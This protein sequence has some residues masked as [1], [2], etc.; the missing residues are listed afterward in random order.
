ML[1][2]GFKANLCVYR[3]EDDAW[4]L[5]GLDLDLGGLTP[6]FDNVESFELTLDRCGNPVVMALASKYT[7]QLLEK[8]DAAGSPYILKVPVL[9]HFVVDITVTG[10][11]LLDSGVYLVQ[12]AGINTSAFALQIDFSDPLH[13]LN[14]MVTGEPS[15]LMAGLQPIS[16]AGG[17]TVT[18]N[19]N[20]S[21][22]APGIHYGELKVTAPHAYHPYLIPVRLAKYGT[23]RTLP[24]PGQY[25]DLGSAAQNA[26]P[27][28]VIT[29]GGGT[30]DGDIEGN[31][32]GVEI[33]GVSP[34]KTVIENVPGITGVS[35]FTISN[36][37]ILPDSDASAPFIIDFMGI[38]GT[39]T[40][41]NVLFI[42]PNRSI[43]IRG[44]GEVRF[45]FC[46]VFSAFGGSYQK[47][48]NE[49]LT[50]NTLL[51]EDATVH[52]DH[53]I[54]CFGFITSFPGT[55]NIAWSAIGNAELSGIVNLDQ[56]I[57]ASFG[58][59]GFVNPSGPDY[60]FHLMSTA[61]HWDDALGIFTPDGTTSP[62]IDAGNIFRGPG[63]EP[64]PNLIP[65]VGA[66]GGTPYASR[67]AMTAN[68]L[69]QSLVG[70]SDR[71]AYSMFCI[72]MMPDVSYTQFWQQL[73]APFEGTYDRKKIRIFSWNPSTLS[74]AEYPNLP[75]WYPGISFWIIISEDMEFDYEGVVSPNEIGR[76]SCRERV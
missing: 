47:I 28:D 73:L 4:S 38:E 14:G 24:V 42:L 8:T 68:T 69:E 62:L 60:D 33:R 43:I 5:L 31:I 54:L 70:G 30:Y 32:D 53:S 58:Q 1:E 51:V 44:G 13:N 18:I 67:T 45:E 34:D 39:V 65:N 64:L 63:L 6:G 52:I 57:Q 61:G 27:G 22:V 66:Y 59:F 50:P 74:Y 37:T 17:S 40:F 12:Q 16:F 20:A 25:P 7:G 35:D 75:N 71:T 26:R 36:V 2:Y 55:T 11:A 76:A 23:Q 46:T 29:L 19:L 21:S 48:D 10:P 72:P 56:M 3:Y 41:K 49:L 15:G 9:R